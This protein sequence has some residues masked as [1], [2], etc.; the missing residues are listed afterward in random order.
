MSR[1]RLTSAHSSL[2]FPLHVAPRPNTTQ[3]VG[4]RRRTQEGTRRGQAQARAAPRAAQGGASRRGRR[5]ET[6][7]GFRTEIRL[8]TVSASLILPRSQRLGARVKNIR[9]LVRD[10]VGS[11]PYE[12]RL[13]ELLKVGRDKRALKLAKRKVRRRPDSR[14]FLGFVPRARLRGARRG[15]RRPRAGPLRRSRA[16][17]PRADPHLGD[18][19]SDPHA[20]S[21]RSPPPQHRPAPTGAARR[22]AR[23][24]AT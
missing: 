22:S 8:L 14:S 6:R 20:P 9:E 11:A 17:S 7:R 24:W 15:R 3:D 5:R 10:V 23:R 21:R 19:S 13:M 12:K 4:H 1:A 16:R 2:H 18:P